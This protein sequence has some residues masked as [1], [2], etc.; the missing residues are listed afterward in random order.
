MYAALR[1]KDLTSNFWNYHLIE[2][3]KKKKEKRASSKLQL[4]IQCTLQYSY[5]PIKGIYIK[6]RTCCVVCMLMGIYISIIQCNWNKLSHF[7]VQNKLIVTF[8]SAR[9]YKK[10]SFYTKTKV[11]PRTPH[12][13]HWRSENLAHNQKEYNFE[14]GHK[15]TKWK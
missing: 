10:C 12:L 8:S 14:K 13:H 2:P 5:F 4:S 15:Y 11:E 3:K 1:S 6:V 9:S 7:I